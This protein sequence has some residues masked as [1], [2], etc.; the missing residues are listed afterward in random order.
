MLRSILFRAT[1][2]LDVLCGDTTWTAER[3]IPSK[4]MCLSILWRGTAAGAVPIEAQLHIWYDGRLRHITIDPKCVQ[5][6]SVSAARQSATK[7]AT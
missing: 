7:V 3:V 2:P 5:A 1:P 4:A 6:Y